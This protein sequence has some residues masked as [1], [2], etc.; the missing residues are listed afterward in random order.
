MVR[1]ANQCHEKISFLRGS[2]TF[3]L[4]RGVNLT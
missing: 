2:H 1:S 3:P 4:A